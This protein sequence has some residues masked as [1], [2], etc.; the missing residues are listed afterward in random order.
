MANQTHK[1]GGGNGIKVDIN[2]TDYTEEITAGIKAAIH[3]AL[4]RIGDEIIS[5]AGDLIH[6]VTGN[7]RRSLNKRVRGN[8]V[9]VG[10]DVEYARYV[11][12]GT[13]R[14]K[15]HPYLRPAVTN[16][17]D[18]WKQIIEDELENGG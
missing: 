1:S 2:I 11:E 9:I 6:N 12:E 5:Y 10:T 13:S 3:R 18:E 7:L 15:P 4:V 17:M 16:H 8:S 14:S